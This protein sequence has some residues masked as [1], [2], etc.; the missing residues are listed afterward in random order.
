MAITLNFG[1]R[2]N[3]QAAEA[4]ISS[5]QAEEFEAEAQKTALAAL[6]DPKTRLERV[7]CDALEMPCRER[8]LRSFMRRAFRRPIN[9]EELN[10]YLTV[11]ETARIALL[12][13]W[14]G[15]AVA[16]AGVLQS[17]N[18]LYR[19]AVTDSNDRLAHSLDLAT[20]LSFF[21]WNTIPDEQ[22][23]AI[24]EK[25][26][27]VDPAIFSREV[28]RLIASPRFRKGGLHFFSD[29]L[30]LVQIPNLRKDR[31]DFPGFTESLAS[32]MRTEVEMRIGHQLFDTNGD[33][34]D[35]FIGKETFVNAELAAHYGL[36]PTGA[37]PEVFVPAVWPAFEPRSGWLGHAG[38]LSLR[39]AGG[40]TSPTLRGRYIVSELLCRTIPPPPDATDTVFQLPPPGV[41]WS[42]R[43]RLAEHAKNPACRSCHINMD[44]MGFA[45]QNFDA[46]GA[47]RSTE[48]GLPIDPS[49]QLDDV[50]FA[51]AAQLGQVLR[52]HPEVPGCLVR[53]L[54][55]YVAGRHEL[56]SEETL[57]A[58]L[59]RRFAMQGYHIPALF[60]DLAKNPWF[61]LPAIPLQTVATQC[62]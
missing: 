9:N 49:G 55:R 24:A 8:F 51:D 27:L 35:I 22:L 44:P 10:R 54:F 3:Q 39:S 42:A 31:D 11:S 16:V 5:L 29:W 53:Q 26:E 46:V 45:L 19:I 34:R 2:T 30:G 36:P 59:E 43:Q 62:E 41:Q 7:G 60:Q 1:V 33:Y 18:F 50:P 17:P 57:L 58:G 6:T 4:G 20:R 14:R 38:I 28:E 37:A 40:G 56:E 48:D 12:D 21:L 52:D 47:Y 32:A 15:L 61:T 23:L 25:G 13:P